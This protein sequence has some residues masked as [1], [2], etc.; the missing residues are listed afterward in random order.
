M[1]IFQMMMGNDGNQMENHGTWF[2]ILIKHTLMMG[3]EHEIFDSNTYLPWLNH[4]YSLLND[5][6]H[7]E[8]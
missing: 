7:H 4:L 1:K 2:P 3:K 8:C 6:E 5:G